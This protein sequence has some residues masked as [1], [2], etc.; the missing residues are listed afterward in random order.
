MES[1]VEK[2]QEAKTLNDSREFKFFKKITAIPYL[3]VLLALLMPL[4][5]VSCT[6]EESHSKPIMEASIYDLAT[7]VNLDEALA[8]DASKQLHNMIDKNEATQK[9]LTSVMPNF[10]TMEPM[11]Y[12]WGIAI[13]VLLA[14]AFTFVSP[15]GSLT[16]GMLAMF[17]LWAMLMQLDGLC[18]AIGIPM[19]RVDPGVGIYA[20]SA[21]ILIG[22]A[23]NLAVII[24]PIV[25]EFRAKK[26]A[27]KT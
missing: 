3:L 9:K 26:K 15:L 20:A 27:K 16:M 11:R 21:L 17:S 4:A 10:P 2:N 23:M 6:F 12:L 13:A 1:K 5:N 8:P 22:S 25:E 18:S 24:R 7:G 19:L 14:A